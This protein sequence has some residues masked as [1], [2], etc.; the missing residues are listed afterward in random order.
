MLCDESTGLVEI[1][2]LSVPHNATITIDKSSCRYAGL[3]EL[4]TS[5]NPRVPTISPIFLTPRMSVMT[6]GFNSETEDE[7][8][9]LRGIQKHEKHDTRCAPEEVTRHIDLCH[10]G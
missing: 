1:L 9:N 6:N 3:R 5:A 8:K 2:S 4:C 10:I 7:Q